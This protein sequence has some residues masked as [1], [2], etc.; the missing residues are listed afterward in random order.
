[1][2]VCLQFFFLHWY[3]IMLLI[4]YGF[5]IIIATIRS[6]SIFMIVAVIVILT[7]CKMKSSVFSHFGFNLIFMIIWVHKNYLFLFP[8]V[9]LSRNLSIFKR[10]LCSKSNWVGDILGVMTY[11]RNYSAFQCLSNILF[12]QFTGISSHLL[13]R[14]LS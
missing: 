7:Y 13:S 1:M 12:C 10:L 4:N 6:F 14:K 11:M 8:M 9:C 2:F 5:L 3:S